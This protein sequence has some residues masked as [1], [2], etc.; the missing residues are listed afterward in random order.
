MALSFTLSIIQFAEL[1]D[2]SR[3]PYMLLT[4]AHCIR[5]IFPKALFHEK[6]ATYAFIFEIAWSF[7]SR[8]NVTPT[9]WIINKC[10]H[11]V[12]G[13]PA[14]IAVKYKIYVYYINGINTRDDKDPKTNLTLPAFVDNESES[15]TWN[16]NGKCHRDERDLRTGLQLPAEFARGNRTIYWMINNMMIR[17]D[18]SKLTGDVLP[19]CIHINER[20]KYIF[21]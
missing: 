7:L 14:S 18:K 11:R 16:K 5:H 17:K 3:I 15:Y 8:D 9:N 21:I 12:G 4:P 1:R 13:L 10:F 6:D 19:H 20:M 2:F